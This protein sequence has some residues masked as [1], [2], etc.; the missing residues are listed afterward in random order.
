MPLQRAT[1]R[2]VRWRSTEKADSQSQFGSLVSEQS[3]ECFPITG[4]TARLFD[5]KFSVFQCGLKPPLMPAG[6]GVGARPRGAG[7]RTNRGRTTGAGAEAE[8]P[9]A[10]DPLDSEHLGDVLDLTRDRVQKVLV[11]SQYRVSHIRRSTARYE[12]GCA[13]DRRREQGKATLRRLAAV[14]TRLTVQNLFRVPSS[15]KMTFSLDV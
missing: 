5:V 14:K 4:P 12:R 3:I 8:N 7:T 9:P 1:I 2:K 10:A 11:K 6:T 15:G 13:T